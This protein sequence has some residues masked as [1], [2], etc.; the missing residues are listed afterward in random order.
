[1]SCPQPPSGTLDEAAVR[2]VCSLAN[3]STTR[4]GALQRLADANAPGMRLKGRNIYEAGLIGLVSDSALDLRCEL[5]A[6]LM[7]VH[8]GRGSG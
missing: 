6:V 3:V 7:C 4:S 2:T 1:M 8:A 5:Q